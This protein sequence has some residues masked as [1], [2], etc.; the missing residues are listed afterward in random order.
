MTARVS[1]V[2]LDDRSWR[3]WWYAFLPV[4]HCWAWA[5]RSV[6]WSFYRGIQVWGNGWP[7]MWGFP[8]LAYVWWIAIASGGTFVSAFF[9][10][11]R[12]EWRTSINRLAE[13]MTLFAAVCAGIYPILHLGPAVVRLLAVSLSQHND[14][15]AAMEVAVTVGFHG[16]AD[17]RRGISTVL[18]PW[19]NA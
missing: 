17:L 2:P 5:L 18:V 19:R 3:G 4:P 9:F 15:L 7:T 16:V 1:A 10:L 8:I 6:G 11:V 12:V 14:A 13:T